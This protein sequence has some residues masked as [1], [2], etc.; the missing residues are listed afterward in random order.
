[1]N[2]DIASCHAGMPMACA[3]WV[4]CGTGTCP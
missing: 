3:D 1:V 2:C 4:T